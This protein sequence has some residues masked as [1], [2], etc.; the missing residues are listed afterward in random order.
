MIVWMQ[1]AA[2]FKISWLHLACLNGSLNIPKVPLEHQ[3]V[4][5][6]KIKSKDAKLFGEAIDIKS[7]LNIDDFEELVSKFSDNLES[8]LDA[9]APL[10]MKMV[11]QYPPKAWFNDGITKQ[12]TGC[13]KQGVCV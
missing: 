1:M 8:T 7:L 3:E 13:K 10:K 9:M 2:Y 11:T 6:W 12:E 4:Q 5:Y